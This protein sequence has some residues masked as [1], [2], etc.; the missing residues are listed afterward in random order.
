MPKRI[1][2]NDEH[3]P[4]AEY[5]GT[6]FFQRKALSK[7][8]GYQGSMSVHEHA[9]PIEVG[10]HTYLSLDD[11][12]K[13]TDSATAARRDAAAVFFA[14]VRSAFGVGPSGEALNVDDISRA[15][16]IAR[17]DLKSAREMLAEAQ[18]RGA[19]R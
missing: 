1:T 6:L 12:K 14:K 11:I 19:E 16:I 9:T 5:R 15:W 10:D 4:T 3:V 8:L 7:A 17:S 13:S 2:L 18:Q